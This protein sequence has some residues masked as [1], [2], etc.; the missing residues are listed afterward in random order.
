MFHTSLIV[1][2]VDACSCAYV[3]A[4]ACT[5]AFACNMATASVI[6]LLTWFCSFVCVCLC[7][8]VYVIGRA[9]QWR[10]CAFYQSCLSWLQSYLHVST[11]SSGPQQVRA[12]S[13]N[14]CHMDMTHHMTH[15]LKEDSTED[16]AHIKQ[17]QIRRTPRFFRVMS[18]VAM[19][20]VTHTNK[21]CCQVRVILPEFSTFL[22]VN[23]YSRYGVTEIY[24]RVFTIFM[25]IIHAHS[26]I[27][28]SVCG[29]VYLTRHTWIKGDFADHPQFFMVFIAMS[30]V[31]SCT[32]HLCVGVWIRM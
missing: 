31:T 3:Y 32:M 11:F 17:E 27:D 25:I 12:I 6:W 23:I 20:H 30:H 13:P 1:V 2:C 22:D 26:C 5:C 9:R 18:L 28:A 21:A 10:P 16:T 15:E 8:C 7:V 4:C 29:C 19:G 14:P 24:R